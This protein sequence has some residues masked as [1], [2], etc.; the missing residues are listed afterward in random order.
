MQLQ[1]DRPPVAIK[2]GV[3]PRQPVV[4]T[5][6]DR[7][8]RR[9]LPIQGHQISS[10]DLFVARVRTLELFRFPSHLVLSVC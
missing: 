3:D 1:P 6:G 4:G 7:Q 5:S 8:Q 2:E 10:A 9:W